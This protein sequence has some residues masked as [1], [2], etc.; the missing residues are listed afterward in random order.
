MVR[1]PLLYVMGVRGYCTLGS[2]RV[3]TIPPSGPVPSPV[4]IFGERAGK[5]ENKWSRPF[6]GKSGREL[7]RY[8]FNEGLQ[9]DDIFVWNVCHDYKEKDP[10]PTPEELARDW[11]K[12]CEMMQLVRPQVV[13]LVGRYAVHQFLPDVELEW[14]HGRAFWMDKWRA[15]GVPIYHPAYALRKPGVS[16][17][18]WDDFHNFAETVRGNPVQLPEDEY[19]APRYLLLH[20]RLPLLFTDLPLYMDT[21]GSADSPWGLSFTQKPGEAYV[22]LSTNPDLLKRLAAVIRK[23]DLLVVL[24]NAMHDLGVLRSMGIE[25]YKF[26]DTMVRAHHLCLYPQG[27]KPLSR[28]L[29]G[30]VQQDY[31]DVVAGAGRDKAVDWLLEAWTWANNRWPEESKAHSKRRTRGSGGRKSRKTSPPSARS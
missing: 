25:G 7:D 5:D 3:R 2:W 23:L 11:P 22:I 20:D 21:E 29:C 19:V 18:V 1:L 15:W 24:H 16:P 31:A 9:R 10:D 14:G 4:A 30:A 17:L 12:V 26:Y 27:L 8:L 6:C 13:G 28:R